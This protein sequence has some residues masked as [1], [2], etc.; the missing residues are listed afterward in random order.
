MER[1]SRSGYNTTGKR[2]GPAQLRA[3][4]AAILNHHDLHEMDG[5]RDQDVRGRRRRPSLAR[6]G[7]LVFAASCAAYVLLSLLHHQ[8]FHPGGRLGYF[9]LRLYRGAAHLLLDDGSLYDARIVRWAHFT[10]PPLAA[11][12]LTPLVVLPLGADEI[13]A[14]A[15]NIAALVAVLWFAL[16][17]PWGQL[18]REEETRG[19]VSWSM[20]ALAAAV[21]L[22]LDPIT[23]TLGY[24]QVNLVI[25]LLIL[26]DLSRSDAAKA[27][28]AMIGLAA[29]LKLTPLIFVPYLLISRRLHA[30]F[31]A[32]GTFAATIAFAFV[33]APADAQRYWG[34]LIF[35]SK[36]I[37]GCCT[38]S[39]QSLRGAILSFAPW[40]GGAPLLVIT[41]IVAIGGIAFAALAARRGDEAMG[42]SICALTGL[43]VSPVSWIHHWA[44]AVPALVLL[45]ARA[46][47]HRSSV[48]LMAIAALA[49]VGYSYLPELVIQAYRGRSE[50]PVG[51]SLASDSY[52]LVG[53]AVLAVACAV[54]Y[55][56]SLRRGRSRRRL[57]TS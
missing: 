31:V 33:L 48:G 56:L 19:H 39:N 54:E 20:V 50:V 4:A 43:L 24:G 1:S 55:R 16:R 3:A 30:A 45:A 22:W 23:T 27:K 15:I 32:L 35:D 18:G 25:A 2:V 52:V 14:T 40:T 47:R 51:W 53:V 21:A 41:V 5:L 29:G 36:R 7:W 9:D 26:W 6:S 38:A 12:A 17:L 46:Y 57:A 8:P 28:G 10:Y 44:L 13:V 11:V 34:S 49:V 37:G 42:F